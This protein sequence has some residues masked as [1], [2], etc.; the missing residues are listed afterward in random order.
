MDPRVKA[1]AEDIRRQYDTSRAID[2]LLRRSQTALAEMR[3]VPNKSTQITELEQRL[4]RASQP[5]GQLFGAVEQIDDAPTPVVMTA[6]KSTSSTVET[7]LRE[8]EQL[9]GR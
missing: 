1:P 3:K 6:W 8:W 7:A 2:A 9:K 5:L 4:T